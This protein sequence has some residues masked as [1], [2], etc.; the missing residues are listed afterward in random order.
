MHLHGRQI[1]VDIRHADGSST[2]A[3]DIPGWN[4]HWQQFYYY[5]Q[6]ISVVAGDTIHLACTYDNSAASQPV[7]NGVQQ[8]PADL[9]W[10]E[11]TTDEMCL[12]YLYFTLP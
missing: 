2:C 10:G 4:F 12:D 7:I 3:V 5:K 6:P 1:R 11:K 8:P 9:R